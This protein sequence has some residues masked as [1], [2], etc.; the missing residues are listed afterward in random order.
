MESKL[1]AHLSRCDASALIEQLG[2]R[3]LALLKKVGEGAV[4]PKGLAALTVHVFGEDGVL[5]NTALRHMIFDKLDQEEG[6]HLC[7]LLGFPDAAP[8]MTLKGVEFDN[9]QGNARRLRGYFNITSDEDETPIEATQNAV[10][11]H[12]L[13]TYQGEAYRKLRRLIGDPS[14]CALVHMPFGAGKLRAVA[15]AILDLYRAEPDG[16]VVLWLAAGPALCDEVFAELNKVWLQLG[17]RNVT[18][19]R[20]YGAH[21][22]PD[23]A[24]IKNGLV[25]ADVARIC[26]SDE[27]LADL[28]RRTRI[29]V[30][31]DAESL[32]HTE[33]S[34]LIEAMY[35]DG[36]FSLIGVSASP[37]ATID[38]LSA[39][40]PMST[41]FAGNSIV[42]DDGD[43]IG[44]LRAAGEIDEIV[45]RIEPL[46]GLAASDLTRAGSEIDSSA[47]TALSHD[48]DRNHAIIEFVL[49]QSKLL[50]HSVVVYC[51]SAEQARLFAGLFL[52]R[53]TRAAAISGD[54]SYTQ[55]HNALQ[56]YAARDDKILCV[57]DCFI[58]GSE[59]PDSSLIVIAVP[60]VSSSI[61]NE[62]IGRLASGRKRPADPL[63]VVLLADAVP[64]Y[65][66]LAE[67]IGN[68]DALQI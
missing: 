11:A 60:V 64:D 39:L 19:Y 62:V 57:H 38:K 27:G 54:M 12:Q 40:T 42:I 31:G 63:Q 15:T 32:R 26:A 45:T 44:L 58:T 25:V 21:L 29:L 37:A 16:R 41:R 9:D 52:L 51:A 30:L 18:A 46:S 13:R 5:K 22:M 8:A 53:G 56:R 59:F 1:V 61:L 50:A 28:A 47:L 20:L 23:L 34:D 49:D 36:E 6:A 35:R 10:A 65:L 17:S 68:W 66:A 48:V 2:E 33:V 14:A 24:N 67:G 7:R 3:T 43:P 55:R 4:V